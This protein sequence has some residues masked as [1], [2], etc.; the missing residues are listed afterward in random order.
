MRVRRYR[1]ASEVAS[2]V[3][4]DISVESNGQ[5]LAWAKSPGVVEVTIPD[6]YR[7]D[8][9]RFIAQVLDVLHDSLLVEQRNKLAGL[10][11]NDNPHGHQVGV[12]LG[13]GDHRRNDAR[14]QLARHPRLLLIRSCIFSAL[15]RISGVTSK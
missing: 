3:N 8:P 15:A 14:Q 10:V 9:L 1:S 11:R 7:K 13:R 5:Q 12:Q 2:V 4:A 6:Q